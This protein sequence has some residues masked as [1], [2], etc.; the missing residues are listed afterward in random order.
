M[1]ETLYQGLERD[2]EFPASKTF[3]SGTWAR[4]RIDQLRVVMPVAQCWGLGRVGDAP[5]LLA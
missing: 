3:A 5:R 4:R 2:G 1:S